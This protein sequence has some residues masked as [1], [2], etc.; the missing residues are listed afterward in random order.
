MLMRGRRNDPFKAPCAFLDALTAIV[1]RECF[2]GVKIKH[3]P[4]LSGDEVHVEVAALCRG[5]LI[6]VCHYEHLPE[7]R[8]LYRDGTLLICMLCGGHGQ[9]V[10]S[11]GIRRH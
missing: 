2:V 5:D 4:A 6:L 9:G 3:L 11:V 8:R 10:A 1:W 7:H